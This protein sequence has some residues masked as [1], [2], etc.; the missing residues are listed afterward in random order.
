MSN[1]NE[2]IIRSK[3]KEILSEE[4]KKI[5]REDYNKIQYKIEEFENQLIETVKE[6]RKVNDSMPEGLKLICNNRLKNVTEN[7]NNSHSLIKQLKNKIKEHKKM[8]YK[9]NQIDEKNK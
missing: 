7:L 2:A 4:T 8:S 3:I 6:L 5:R 1:I 9:S